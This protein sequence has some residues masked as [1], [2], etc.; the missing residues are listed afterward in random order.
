MSGFRYRI[1]YWTGICALACVP[2]A[3]G[4]PPASKLAGHTVTGE[5]LLA[6]VRSI[7]SAD[8][9]SGWEQLDE[10]HVVLQ[11]NAEDHY[12]ITLKSRCLG[13]NWAQNVGVTMSNNTIWAG[14]DAI[15]A[16][17]NQCEIELINPVGSP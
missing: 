1:V 10:Q 3:L 15:T 5:R 12:L 14:F 8:R 7:E 11:L 4:L 13:L 9:I 2:G 17:G 16:D 6:P